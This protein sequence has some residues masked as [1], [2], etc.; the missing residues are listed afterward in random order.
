MPRRTDIS[1]VLI[2]AVPQRLKPQAEGDR[3]GGPEGPPFQGLA[4]TGGWA[5]LK[6]RPSMRFLTNRA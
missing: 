2:E 6:P 3:I 5:G 1:K 4:L